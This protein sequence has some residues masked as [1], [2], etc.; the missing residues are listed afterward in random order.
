MMS[1]KDHHP[2]FISLYS[3]FFGSPHTALCLFWPADMDMDEVIIEDMAQ[4]VQI[5]RKKGKKKRKYKNSK[6]KHA[7][8]HNFAFIQLRYNG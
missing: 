4:A 2:S 6:G 3:F 5:W 7:Y 1:N 8:N